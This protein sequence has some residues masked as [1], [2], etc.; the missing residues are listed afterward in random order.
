[1]NLILKQ[2]LQQEIISYIKNNESSLYEEN[3]KFH[4]STASLTLD[5]KNRQVLVNYLLKYIERFNPSSMVALSEGI[6]QGIIDLSSIIRY[7]SQKPYFYYNLDE[8]VEPMDITSN[9]SD[10]MLFIPYLSDK[11]QFLNYLKFLEKHGVVPKLILC[12]FRETKEDLENI[13]KKKHIN[14]QTVFYL[15]DILFRLKEHKE[16]TEKLM[17]NRLYF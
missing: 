5:L 16:I 10:C 17:R 3:N 8:P 14:F 9:L 6:D 4:I 15:K 13:C 1:L 11:N 7:K 12:I 2:L